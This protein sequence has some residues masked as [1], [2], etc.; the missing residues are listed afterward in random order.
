MKKNE[1]VTKDGE[2]GARA[3]GSYLKG[4]RRREAIVDAAMVIFGR[5]GYQNAAFAAVAEEVG[6]TLPGLLHHFPRK[7]DLLLAVLERRDEMA[8]TMLPAE[9][10]D[11]PD[12]LKAL[13]A[14][15]RHNESIPGVVRVFAL[16]SVECLA[17]DHPAK[18]WF[19][20]RMNETRTMIA[21]AFRVGIGRGTLDAALSPES[22]ASEVIAMMDGLQEQWL[23]SGQLLDMSGIFGAYIKRLVRDL[24][25]E[26]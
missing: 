15:V 21:D 22:L 13:V 11:W 6:L 8:R 24:S 10:G 2:S 9:G 5:Q 20:R 26:A 17:D 19:E 7:V 18:E 23:R 16:L 3:R 25:Q 12:M 4:R 14:I 1:T